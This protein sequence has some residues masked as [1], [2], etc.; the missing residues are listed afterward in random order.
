MASEVNQDNKHYFIVVF[1]TSIRIKLLFCIVLSFFKIFTIRNREKNHRLTIWKYLLHIVRLSEIIKISRVIYL[2][3]TIT[4]T[5]AIT[6]PSYVKN[7][8]MNRED[9][10]LGKSIGIRK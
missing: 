3:M 8:V 1:F 2:Q 9:V 7:C 4:L 6:Y 5:I 10:C